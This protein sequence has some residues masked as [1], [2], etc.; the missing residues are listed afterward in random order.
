[1]CGIAGY[2]DLIASTDAGAL[3][4]DADAMARAMTHRGPDDRGVWVDAPSGVAL[5][6]ARLSI[7]DLSP[8]GHQPMVGAAGRHVIVYNGEIY[9]AKELRR[10]LDGISWRGHSDTEVI[11]EACARWGVEATV[12]K[13]IGMFAFALWDRET[14][15]LTLARDRFGIKPL[16]WGEVDGKLVFGSELKALMALQGWRREID[17]DAL[18][19]YLRFNYVPAPHSIFR[20]VRKLTPGTVLEWRDGRGKQRTF[21]SLRE[22]AK[23]G[24]ANPFDLGDGEAVDELDRLIR[25][26]VRRRMVADVPVGA[27]LSGGIDSSTVVAAMKAE[28]TGPVHTFSIGMGEPGYNEAQHAKAIARHLGTEHTELY[29]TPDDARAVIP[30]L[31]TFYDEPFADSS[32]IPTFL[33]SKLARRSVIVSLSGDG[34]DELF[35]GY[36]R[37]FW[38]ERLRRRTA[39]LPGFVKHALAGGIRALSPGQWDALGGL[40]PSG[41]RPRLLGIKAHKAADLLAIEDEGALFRRLVTVWEDPETLVAGASEPHGVLWDASLAADIAPFQERMQVMDGLTYLSDDILAKVD[42]ASMAVSLEARVPLLDHRIAEFAYRLPR[43]MRVRDGQGKWILREVLSRRVP[44]E[45]FERPKMGFG[46]PIGEWLRGPLRDWAEDLLDPAKLECDG[47]LDAAPIR[48]AWD[49]HLTGRV[50]NEVKLWTVLMYQSWRDH[51]MGGG[52]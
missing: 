26:A 49:A 23:R 19:S 48:A 9:N 17:R 47:L 40:L 39:L 5:A 11:L 44:R 33:V 27:F 22:V 13:L 41:M 37:Y 16:Y 14:R 2:L 38:G 1:M 35:C 8:A 12:G 52:R 20:G 31:P 25:D 34:G 51:W 50:N 32:Q 46:I 24:L 3:E 42:R 43:H 21:W 30:A 45:L 36:N 10:D 15:T 28:S 18:A 6:Q 29:V 7:I 4:R